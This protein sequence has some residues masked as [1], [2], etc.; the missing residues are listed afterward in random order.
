MRDMFCRGKAINFNCQ[1]LIPNTNGFRGYKHL[2][3]ASFTKV[4]GY[5]L[6]DQDQLHQAITDKV[7]D[8]MNKADFSDDIGHTITYGKI[9]YEIAG[10][11]IKV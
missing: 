9:E 8:V 7:L 11:T 5:M 3:K 4:N 10:S 2:E 1:K 6:Y